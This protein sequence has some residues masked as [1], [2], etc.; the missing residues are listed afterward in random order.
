MAG[1]KKGRPSK[2]LDAKM[3]K[4]L[5]D[6]LRA[7]AMIDA[8]CAAVGISRTSFFDWMKRG[9]ADKSG[10]YNDF[11]DAVKKALA[12]AENSLVAGIRNAGTTQWQA[13]AWLLERRFRERW[14]RDLPGSETRPIAN[15]TPPTVTPRKTSD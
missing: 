10:I 12:D 3:V 4:A 6:L 11:A 7:G 13:M 14:S 15:S 9:Q 2:A 1:K 8:A 5:T